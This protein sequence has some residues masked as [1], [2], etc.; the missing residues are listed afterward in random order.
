LGLAAAIGLLVGLRAIAALSFPDLVP[1]LGLDP[2]PREGLGVEWSGQAVWPVEL[3]A[4]ALTQ[5][6][7][8]LAALVLACGAVATLN[9]VIVLAEAST[10]RRREFAVRSALG[11]TPWVLARALISEVRTLTLAGVSLGVIAGVVA[12]AAARITWPNALVSLTERAPLDLAMAVT[13]LLALTVAAHLA[14]A[15]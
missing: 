11:A 9:T 13:S 1:L 10:A 12:G 4:A 6:L 5:L 14:A 7:K 15:W 8:A 2:T 3:Q